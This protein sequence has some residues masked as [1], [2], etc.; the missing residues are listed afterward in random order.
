MQSLSVFRHRAYCHYFVMRNLFTGSRQ[1]IAVAIGWQVY[2]I[3]RE[4]RSIEESAFIL[5]LIGLAQFLPILILF[6][7]AGQAADRVDRKIILI[8]CNIVKVGA[9]CLLLI[10][11]H[12][13]SGVALALMFSAAV[14]MGIANSF[15]PS[16]ATSLY[17]LL[18]PREDLPNAVSW[19][20]IGFQTAA[21]LGPAIAGGL[22]LIS[23]NAVYLVAIAMLIVSTIAIATARTPTHQ[24]K[25]DVKALTLIREGFDYL[26][27]RPRVSGA[28]LLDFVVVFFSGA[29]AL[30]P[31]FARDILHVGPE[32]LGLLRAA[33]AVGA[34]IVGYALAA[35][36]LLRRIGFWLLL[37]VALT[38]VSML[39]FGLSSVFWVS[40][41][42]LAG[43]GGA[44]MMSVY[45]RQSLIQLTTPEH[46]RGR[47]AA[48]SFLFV[49]G[50]N[51]LGEF[52][53]GVVARFLGPVGAVMLGGVVA[54]VTAV[55]WIK[56]FPTL[57]KTNRLD[58]G[59][60]PLS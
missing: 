17:P 2:E 55:A 18:V 3:A 48:V 52:E 19:N 13:A 56:I 20:L 23:V 46:L 58:D 34:V 21:I 54:I 30:L 43:Y 37:S 38:G 6:L 10:A 15:A 45:I 39:V 47:V 9:L 16:A 12:F 36:P 1:M 51:E 42:A 33:P 29:T 27:S 28:I 8:A 26:R 31:I 40:L 22:F 59:G 11:S 24:P 50:S 7:I 5:G 60:P 44:D 41:V 14:V 32:G 57:A 35:Y 25:S 4:T 53:S 49:S